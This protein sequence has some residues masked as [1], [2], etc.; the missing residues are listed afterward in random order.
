MMKSIES[1]TSE[2]S[3][4]KFIYNK[5]LIYEFAFPELFVIP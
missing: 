5:R 3:E 4:L 2:A 1:R